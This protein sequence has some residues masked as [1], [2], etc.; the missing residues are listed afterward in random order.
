MRLLISL[1]L[2]WCIPISAFAAAIDDSIDLENR[3]RHWYGEYKKTAP[4]STLTLKRSAT[5][6]GHLH[7]QLLRQETE[8]GVELYSRA[9][10]AV[11]GRGAGVG[12]LR[13]PRNYEDKSHLLTPEEK[14]IVKPALIDAER[15]RRRW[16]GW[17][18]DYFGSEDSYYAKVGSNE[19]AQYALDSHKNIIER[20]AVQIWNL[21]N[22]IDTPSN[23]ANEKVRPNLADALRWLDLSQTATWHPKIYDIRGANDTYSNFDVFNMAFYDSRDLDGI[24]FDWDA[25]YRYIPI[26]YFVIHGLPAYASASSRDPFI[27]EVRRIAQTTPLFDLL[28]DSL[29]SMYDYKYDHRLPSV[30][31]L[32][33]FL[34][35]GLPG[36]D[37]VSPETSPRLTL[38]NQT[39]ILRLF[40]NAGKQ[41]YKDLNHTEVLLDALT[42]FIQYY[43]ACPLDDTIKALVKGASYWP[44]DKNEFYFKAI[45]ILYERALSL[46]YLHNKEALW[47]SVKRIFEL[48]SIDLTFVALKK[49]LAAD[50]LAKGCLDVRQ[51]G[52]FAWVKGEDEDSSPLIERF[53]VLIKVRENKA[54]I[55]FLHDKEIT[56]YFKNLIKEELF[57]RVQSGLLS[58]QDATSIIDG[59]AAFSTWPIGDLNRLDP[60][61]KAT[62]Q[63]ITT[64][65][66]L[67][68]LMRAGRCTN[69]KKLLIQ[70]LV[71]LKEWEAITKSLGS[72]GEWAEVL[73][74][75]L[76][77]LSE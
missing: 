65:E 44:S 49:E 75:T 62:I 36:L 37:E 30:L 76:Q 14:A 9:I 64:P 41:V 48:Y 26:T 4:A 59:L 77:L 32:Q 11:I 58:E 66:L 55:P 23:S 28:K 70:R 25:T 7:N 47:E 5:F 10:L 39:R 50:L 71:E 38:A 54:L 61:L 74:Y 8:E 12:G 60:G 57:T 17:A 42:R 19:D 31:V 72:P 52:S 35:Q 33:I 24:L 16:S 22:C 63:R 56:S 69:Y 3:L 13:T 67:L 34:D 53:K 1:F 68:D 29:G 45:K 2:F 18:E 20:K 51:I 43:P 6:V 27:Q 21:K 15:L 40:E 73:S 46:N